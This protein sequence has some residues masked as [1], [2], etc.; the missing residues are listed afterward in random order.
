LARRQNRCGIAF[1]VLILCA[2]CNRSAIEPSE[3]LVGASALPSAARLS[4]ETIEINRA[5]GGGEG[6]GEH[7]LSY[8]LG[9][10]DK[11]VVVHTYRPDDTVLGKEEFQLSHDVA[12]KARERLWRVRPEKLEGINSDVRPV[13]CRRYSPHDLGDVAVGFMRPDKVFGIFTLPHPASCNTHA[14][15]EARKLLHQVL[16]S[17]PHSKV[18]TDFTARQRVDEAP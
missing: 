15:M 17:L 10:D 7:F 5:F 3:S 8:R 2:S 6:F 14:A 4:Q 13:G 11:L 9:S 12:A 1:L 16:R 18:A